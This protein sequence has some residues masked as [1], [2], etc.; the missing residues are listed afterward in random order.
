MVGALALLLTLVVETFEEEIDAGSLETFEDDVDAF[1]EEEDE[2][3]LDDVDAFDED[4]EEEDLLEEE[5]ADVDLI[6][7][8]PPIAT[9]ALAPPLN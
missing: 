3:L 9:V 2:D 6:P 5:T 8:D 1:D 4:D 7:D